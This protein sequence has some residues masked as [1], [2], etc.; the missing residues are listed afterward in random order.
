MS[1]MHQIQEDVSVII[2][3]YTEKR[4]HDLCNAVASVQQ[5]TVQPREIIVVIDYNPVLL[6]CV[7]KHLSAVTVIEN[8]SAKG[9]SGARNSGAAIAQGTIVAFLDDDAVAEPDWI[10][11][12]LIPYDD[13]G[14][15]GVGGRINP[16]WPEKKP[17]WFPEEFHWVVG[18]TYRGMPCK[19]APIRNMIGAN[20]SLRRDTLIAFGGFSETSGWNQE[21][22]GK[23]A[24]YLGLKRLRHYAY[25]EDTEFC[26]R[27]THLRQNCEQFYYTPTALVK[28]LVTSQRT[29]WI[30]FLWRCYYEGRGKAALVSLH[31][32]RASL[33]SERTYVLKTLPEGMIRGLADAFDHRDIAGLARIGAIVAGLLA[34]IAGYVV[35]SIYTKVLS[36]DKW[37]SVAGERQV[38]STSL[39]NRGWVDVVQ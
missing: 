10:E 15:V 23:S 28:H 21:N 38:F 29:Q 36:E 37:I 11:Q 4:W 30:Y 27:A 1:K 9:L 22:K 26:I 14:V 34:T 5:Q 25:G 13:L 39:S 8:S 24:N 18:C 20:M 19:T 32:A 12:L 35:G 2:C 16:F 6:E 17:S 3:A 7:K 31:G 33:A